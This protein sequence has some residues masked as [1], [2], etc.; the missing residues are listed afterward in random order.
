MFAGRVTVGHR[1]IQKVMQDSA[2]KEA[3]RDCRAIPPF[4]DSYSRNSSV[5]QTP[6]SRP[7]Y[8]DL[9]DGSRKRR[10]P[11]NCSEAAMLK[12]ALFFFVISIVSGVFGFTGIAAGAA[13]IAK[14]LFFVAVALFVIFLVLGLTIFKSLT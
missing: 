2:Y 14:I 6:E 1:P 13:A 4:V 3:Q 8:D 12:L 11:A 7:A 9:N 5:L 10:R